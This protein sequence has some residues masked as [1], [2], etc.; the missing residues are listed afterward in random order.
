VQVQGGKPGRLSV[1][2]LEV[3]QAAGQG[4]EGDRSLEARQRGPQAEVWP[5][6]KA[7]RRWVVATNVEAVGLVEALWVAV[8]RTDNGD[9][10]LTFWDHVP[11]YLDLDRRHPRRGHRSTV[12]LIAGTSSNWLW[13]SV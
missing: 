2:Q 4:F 11:I 10:R 1:N 8:T 6:S 5:G 7:Q 13:P 9:N 12:E 3:W